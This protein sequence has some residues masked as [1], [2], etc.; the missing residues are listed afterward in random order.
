MLS[1]LLEI[2][3]FSFRNPIRSNII[4]IIAEQPYF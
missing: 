2:Q 4:W 1:T 3:E